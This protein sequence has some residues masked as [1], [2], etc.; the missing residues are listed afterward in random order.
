[1]STEHNGGNIQNAITL[2]E[3][4]GS[5]NA[6]RVN[7]VA[8]TITA[9]SQVTVTPQQ[10]WPD[11]K[12]YIGLVTITGSL[13]APSGNVTLDAGSKTQIVGNITL[14]NSKGFI[15]LVTSYPAFISVPTLDH[16][17]ANTQ[18]VAAYLVGYDY[19]SDN[20]NPIRADGFGIVDTR[21]S[22]SES[23]GLQQDSG[24]AYALRVKVHGN[25]TIGNALV[26]V[27]LGTALDSTNDSV[28]IGGS[29]P[30]GVNGIG[31][32]TV[33]VVNLA[34]TITGNLTLSDPKTF[35]GSVT[36]WGLNAG[37]TKTLI[38]KNFSFA[39]ASVATVAVPSNTFKITSLIAN[40]NATV[41]VR[42]KSGATYLIGNVSLS[43]MLNPGGGWVQ[44]GSPDSPVYIGLASGAAIVV[45]KE[46]FGQV[47]E[48]AGHLIYFDE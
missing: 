5:L 44:H 25:V 26:T 40:S 27:T 32:A 15:G 30:A 38:P 48:I 17:I 34:R 23:V 10:A 1:M 28:A 8:G 18:P 13:S 39:Q 37:T 3:H 11:P 12:T 24:N 41:G 19:S 14:S 9:S 36:A 43:V 20:W 31:F 42:V 6:K 7:V 33:N 35:I 2:E 21:P 16:A 45:E 4:D 46:D 22:G 29:L 47:A